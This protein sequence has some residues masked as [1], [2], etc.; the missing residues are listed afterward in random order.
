MI[1]DRSI[2]RIKSSDGLH[3]IGTLVQ[4]IIAQKDSS[5]LFVLQLFTN[6]LN[7]I[8]LVGRSNSITI[9]ILVW[10]MRWQY[11]VSL[12]WL[13][14]AWVSPFILFISDHFLDISKSYNLLIVHHVLK[15]SCPRQ[16]GFILSIEVGLLFIIILLLLIFACRCEKYLLERVL[17]VASCCHISLVIVS[18]RLCWI[19]MVIWKT[20]LLSFIIPWV[21]RSIIVASYFWI[22]FLIIWDCNHLILICVSHW[23]MKIADQLVFL[24]LKISLPLGLIRLLCILNYVLIFDLW[25]CL[26]SVV[27]SITWVNGRW[28]LRAIF[29][30]SN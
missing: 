13:W 20:L 21:N 14:I 25:F 6:T 12:R 5:I 8:I 24:G 16:A 28:F 10:S 30:Q 18:H 9:L 2:L 3:V 7:L 22:F 1:K 29:S 19:V 26:S 15:M 4:R 23:F 27:V 11:F 17:R